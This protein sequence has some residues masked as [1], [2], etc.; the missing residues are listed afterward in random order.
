LI[1]AVRALIA[2]DSVLVRE[3]I[4]RLLERAEIDVVAQAADYDDV[5]RKAR[6]HK[7]DVAVVDIRMPPD[8][9]DE[10]I[11]AARTIRGELLADGVLVL[12]QHLEAAYALEL[13]SDGSD[14][15]GYLLKDRVT[16]PAAFVDAVRRVAGGGSALDPQVVQELLGR[17]RVDDPLDK[18][19]PRERDV[20]A[21]M[22][23]GL[24]NGGIAERLVVTEKAVERHVTA[25]F[26]KL[27]LDA[28]P[29]DHRR[30][31]AV[32]KFLEK[33]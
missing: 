30:V 33:G 26:G 27:L 19:T 9:S 29:T 4:A 15:L 14:G 3:G 7:P 28:A 5:L 6:A 16:E 1:R 13:L 23:E 20:L 24:T 25:I 11:R 8:H 10:G 2:D 12:S 21:L 31:L 17:R 18:L 22:A 32:L